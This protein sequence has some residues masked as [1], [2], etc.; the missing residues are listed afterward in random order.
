MKESRND[1]GNDGQ[2]EGS[3]MVPSTITSWTC[4][5]TIGGWGAV[6]VLGGLLLT[7]TGNFD[8]DLT[9]IDELLVEKFYG[10]LGFLL[11]LH[12]N[13]SIAKR[14]GTTGNDA[15]GRTVHESEIMNGAW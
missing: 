3:D 10:L 11:R 12:L 2:R 1:K 6:G 13:K 9:T 8:V 14:T 7:G 5:T 4:T 15:C